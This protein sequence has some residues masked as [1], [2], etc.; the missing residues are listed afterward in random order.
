MSA[1]LYGSVS[2]IGFA[3]F[4]VLNTPPVANAGVDTYSVVNAPAPMN[5]SASSDADGDVLSYQWSVL[6]APLGSL[7]TLQ[8]ASR[9]NPGF[10]A[11]IKGSYV[12]QLIV[13]DGTVDSAPDLITVWVPNRMPVAR[14]DAVTTNEDTSLVIN[15]L[16]NDSDPDGDY[17]RITSI[18]A[19][20]H[21]AIAL[22]VDGYTASYTPNLNF[23]GSDSFSY[24]ISDGDGGTAIAVVNI[25]V[26]P[27]NDAP[28]ASAPAIVTDEDIAA[29]T[30]L[31]VIDPDAG[32]QHSYGI[33]TAPAHASA[34]VDSYG[35]VIYTPQL[36]YNGSDTL[37]VTVTDSAGAH[38]VVTIPV[39][40]NP[41]ND[42][43]IS[44]VDSFITDEDTP[45]HSTSVLTND[46]DV[47]GDVLTAVLIAA[48]S[49]GSLLLDLYGTFVY[50][51]YANWNGTEQ[52]TY[53]AFDGAL[54]SNVSTVTITVNPVNDAPIAM[55][56]VDQYAFV[57]DVVIFDG[58]ASYDV[59]GD[60][61]SYSWSKVTAPTA[62]TAIL[63][64]ASSS[65]SSLIVDQQGDYL[66]ELRVNDG[67]VNSLADQVL[68][69]VPNRRPTA[70]IT[71]DGYAYVDD[72]VTV[73]GYASVD[74]DHDPLTYYWQLTTPQGSSSQLSDPYA[75]APVFTVDQKGIYR[76]S[77][78]V[79]DG[80]DASVVVTQ[81]ITIPNRAPIAR[82]GYDQYGYVCDLVTL[83]GYAS[84]DPDHDPITY[85]WSLTPPQGSSIGLTSSTTM[86]T[87]FIPDITG[88]Y[89]A[90]LQVHDGSVASVVDSTLMTAVMPPV[91]LYASMHT[92]HGTRMLL[93]MPKREHEDDHQPI[94]SAGQQWLE[95]TLASKHWLFTIVNNED[96]FLAALHTGGYSVYGLFT[97][98][99]S[100]DVQQKLA[101]ATF[102]GA[103]LLVVGTDKAKALAH[104]L[105]VKF[106]DNG[107]TWALNVLASPVS[108]ATTLSFAKATK[109][110]AVAAQKA[111]PLAHAR[112][113][114]ED[115][116]HSSIR[117]V[118]TV[119]DYGT[120]HAVYIGLDA[121][122]EI[123]SGVHQGEV[124]NI[125]SNSLDYI[126]ADVRAN[127]GGALPIRVDLRNLAC[128][129]TTG[130][131]STTLPQGVHLLDAGAAIVQSDGSLQ[132]S[133]N[134]TQY[135]QQHW[136]Y[137]ITLPK[138]TRALHLNANV[139][140][141]LPSN[142]PQWQTVLPM[143]VD[144]PSNHQGDHQNDHQGDHQG[145]KK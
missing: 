144:I 50:S 52:F 1:D 33:T 133:F 11:D 69:H 36:N 9:S 8:T 86:R 21:G 18:G 114:G 53:A 22:N 111:I 25:T 43:P 40:V 64:G 81:L 126:R 46:S 90:Q 82:A 4:Q 73:N 110:R 102:Q 95:A 48:P 84:Y 130:Q 80:M 31:V 138:E 109:V 16:S 13:N 85:A 145:E 59:D 60:P 120:G 112:L 92:A 26:K 49:H 5:G 88:N 55:A 39:T 101:S 51:P 104:T 142:P 70:V 103:G 141:Q 117:S 96:D 14:D 115:E 121:L 98:K 132:W 29:K 75:I 67:T 116:E 27:V 122:Q 97:T 30:Q 34:N 7:K 91:D 56:G 61:L 66:F 106:K 124:A 35:R 54:H 37:I 38:A 77:L 136:I 105:G 28:Q 74:P 57:D 129:I 63:S 119:Y 127:A 24:N 19:V 72:V 128:N 87:H 2:D 65:T 15:M 134:I 107:R 89:L 131:V 139:Q 3:A 137:W 93:L 83:D 99:L 118:A 143:Q 68:L 78:M 123:V 10:I 12:L 58:T 17:L 44:V 6:S 32:D 41:V 76:I 94:I 23:N 113:S 20:G 125:V 135:Q 42:A 45:L 47:D 62:S 100:K 71:A 140:A 79:N 108:D